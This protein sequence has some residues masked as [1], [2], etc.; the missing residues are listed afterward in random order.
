MLTVF[1]MKEQVQLHRA[2]EHLKELGCSSVFNELATKK[3]PMF[4]SCLFQSVLEEV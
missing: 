4:F 3:F 1:W 2:R